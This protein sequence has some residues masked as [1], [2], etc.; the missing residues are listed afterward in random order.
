MR[1]SMLSVIIHIAIFQSV[2]ALQPAHTTGR[3]GALVLGACASISCVKEAAANNLDREELE[4]I[5]ARAKNNTLSTRNVIIRAL[6]DEMFDAS[7]LDNYWGGTDCRL[8]ESI[9][10]IDDKAADEVRT[11]NERFRL[12]TQVA[13]EAPYGSPARRRYEA[14]EETYELGKQIEN[15]IRERASNINVKYILDCQDSPNQGINSN[16]RDQYSF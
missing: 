10:K 15:K 1:S 5:R 2:A 6:R 9:A 3:R 8:L 7:E 11:A 12:L 16:R 14:L 4:N 13:K